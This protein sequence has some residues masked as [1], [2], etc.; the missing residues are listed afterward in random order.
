VTSENARIDDCRAPSGTPGAAPRVYANRKSLAHMRVGGILRRPMAEPLEQKICAVAG[1]SWRLREDLLEGLLA[2]WS[3]P[4]KRLLEPDGLDGLLVDL[5]SPSL[6]DEPALCVLRAGERWLKRQKD[7]LLP[8]VGLPCTGAPLLL[9]SERLPRNEAL[10]RALGKAGALLSTDEP[11]GRDLL[12]WLTQRLLQVDTLRVEQPRQVAETL[13]LHRGEEIDAL[14]AAIEQLCDYV[15]DEVLR[16]PAVNELLAGEAEQPVWAFI[17]AFCKG[18]AG[19][20]LRLLHAGRG[21]DPHQALAALTA[22]IRKCLACLAAADEREAL[23]MAGVRGRPNLY[24]TRRRAEELGRRSLLRLLTGILQAQRDLR[25][26]GSDPQLVMELL[27]LNARRVIRPGGAVTKARA[28][29]RV[30][31]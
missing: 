28:R 5:D 8:L 31:T 1:N 23:R 9:V 19:Q 22:E 14:L 4:T 30:T 2:T 16:P 11:R 3:G 17:D 27:V 6:F 10:G 13:I 25:R 24:Y 29:R 18:Q 20:A 26:T 15:G 7:R 12:P 21:L